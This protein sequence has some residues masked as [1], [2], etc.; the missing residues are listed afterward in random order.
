MQAQTGRD[1]VAFP[2]S[3]RRR[4]VPCECFYDVTYDNVNIRSVGLTALP[5]IDALGQVNL[6]VQYK[7]L[8]KIPRI[9]NRRVLVSEHCRFLSD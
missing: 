8:I 5:A 4:F 3:R 1:S 7:I 6:N 9:G 2:G